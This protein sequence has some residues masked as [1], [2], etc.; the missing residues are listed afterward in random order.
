VS[1]T[2]A[3]PTPPA[4]I[5]FDLTPK[6]VDGVVLWSYKTRATTPSWFAT[7]AEPPTPK[8]LVDPA[9]VQCAGLLNDLAKVTTRRQSMPDYHNFSGATTFLYNHSKCI[10]I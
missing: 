3:T 10:V 5:D 8:P 4:K 6:T 7:P 1:V 9:T 2:Q